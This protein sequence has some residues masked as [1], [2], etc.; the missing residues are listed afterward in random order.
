MNLQIFVYETETNLG[1]LST[2]KGHLKEAKC[3][4]FTWSRFMRRP[5]DWKTSAM[6][7]KPTI[8]RT[9]YQ[10]SY[11]GSCQHVVSFIGFT[12]K[13]T[14]NFRPTTVAMDSPQHLQW[15]PKIILALAKASSYSTLWGGR[16]LVS[17]ISTLRQ[18][19]HKPHAPPLWK[20]SQP[21][22]SILREATVVGKRQKSFA[23]IFFMYQ[24]RDSCASRDLLADG[25]QRE[26]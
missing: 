16:G 20:V 26:F 25:W 22:G 18:Q 14:P 13:L 9:A 4:S 2:H 3:P 10:R 7:Y 15:H 21:S 8:C 5:H 6:K 12:W 23:T 17:A 1:K 19:P 24:C 11:N